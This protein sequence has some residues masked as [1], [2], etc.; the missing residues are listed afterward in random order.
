[1]HES[2]KTVFLKVPRYRIPKQLLLVILHKANQKN[3]IN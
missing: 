3:K 1:M 2:D